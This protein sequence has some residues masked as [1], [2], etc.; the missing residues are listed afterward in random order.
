M[1]MIV[2]DV[3]KV[4]KTKILVSKLPKT[5]K[6]L[7]VYETKISPKDKPV[8][9]ILPY[10][11][12]TLSKEVEVIDTK[13]GDS[14]FFKQ[15]AKNFP[16]IKSQALS[17]GRG[18]GSLG[19]QTKGY[20]Q[21]NRAGSYRYSVAKS[22]E[23]LNRVD[24]TVFQINSE[25]LT[26]LL[27]SY[28][29][30][31]FGYLVCIIDENVDYSPFAFVCDLPNNKQLYVPTKHYHTHSSNE[32]NKNNSFADDWD[33]EIYCMD[34]DN[35]MDG[36]FANVNL[37][38]LKFGVLTAFTDWTNYDYYSFSKLLGNC[39]S[40]NML[41]IDRVGGFVNEDIYVTIAAV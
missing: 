29:T 17:F 8:A 10:P 22:L 30:L 24:P 35:A 38:L 40:E 5:N 19:L 34:T 21:V 7:V 16:Q 37:S 31:N 23:E 36:N 28:E 25:V 20:L 3:R 4:S 26:K 15:I 41:K 12:S 11:S 39:K 13:P 9:M 2:G 32:A 1:C 33:H 18:T 6:Q 14:D 27:M